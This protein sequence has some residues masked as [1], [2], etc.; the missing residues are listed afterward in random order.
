MIAAVAFYVFA[1]IL[2]ASA[3]MV[4][5]AR[6]PVHSVLFLI[7]AFF[8]AA[9]L[10][11]LAG[12]EFL[13]MI[14]VIVYVGAVAVLFLFVV[15]MLDINFAELRSR[16]QQFLPVG[17]AVGTVL[18]IELGIVLGGWKL[19]PNLANVRFA[20]NAPDL[21]N[22]AQL[23]RLIYT[24]YVLLFQ[25]AGLVLLVAMIGAIVLTLR[26]NR[27]GSKRQSVARQVARTPADTLEMVDMAVGAGVSVA[28]FRRP[29]ATAVEVPLQEH[30]AHG[31][32][33]DH[34]GGH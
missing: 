23:G 8:N 2:L 24:D 25:A 31:H 9:A 16:F 10:F 12:A 6:N 17:L 18:L 33:D 1:A 28:E 15:M 20:A 14:L 19:A 27:G 5:S 13:A 4:V 29:R 21:H 26:E 7:L 30:E 34:G 32:D 22:T 3:G 11:L